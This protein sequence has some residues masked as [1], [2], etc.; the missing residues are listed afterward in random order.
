M[1]ICVRSVCSESP[2]L[3]P[4]LTPGKICCPQPIEAHQVPDRYSKISLCYRLRPNHPSL[5]E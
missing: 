5:H 2:R 3:S 4:G 1:A